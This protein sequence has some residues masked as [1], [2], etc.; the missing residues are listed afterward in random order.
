M[1]K[2]KLFFSM[3]SQA[4]SDFTKHFFAISI[5]LMVF[6]G[7]NYI[8]S[9]IYYCLGLLNPQQL[10]LPFE[11]SEYFA[12]CA[13][14]CLQACLL[15]VGYIFFMQHALDIVYKRKIAWFHITTAT[16]HALLFDFVVN[17]V[18][19]KQSTQ[20]YFTCDF[21]GIF[22]LSYQVWI[23]LGWSFLAVIVIYLC[24]FRC[25]FIDLFILEAKSSF[26]Q[27]FNQSWDLALGNGILYCL[28]FFV[29]ML[30]QTA[31]VL[32]FQ[33]FY[34]INNHDVLCVQILAWF[35]FAWGLLLRARLFK[36]LR[37]QEA[38]TIIE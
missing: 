30:M 4:W 15:A 34:A 8:S 19:K 5:L 29:P 27:A 36:T 37:E 7:L 1:Q 17:Y 2:L 32:G 31:I 11:L 35:I 3:C 33:Y 23:I 26:M 9:E 10:N 18:T 16:L 12:A 25:L 38:A 22:E 14:R 28:C 21:S 13:I 20:L 6:V 24:M